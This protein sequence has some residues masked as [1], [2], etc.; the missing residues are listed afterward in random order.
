MFGSHTPFRQAMRMKIQRTCLLTLCIFFL[1]F[2]AA[3]AAE[4]S[5]IVEPEGHQAVIQA[6]K[7]EV[8][9]LFKSAVRW[10]RVGLL[11]RLTLTEGIAKGDGLVLNLFPDTSYHATI[12]R[13]SVNVQGTITVRGRLR[14]YPLGYVLISTTGDLS[15]A[16]IRVPELGAEYTIVYDPDSKAHYLLDNDPSKLD[17]LEDAPAVIPPL[18][19]RKNKLKSRHFENASCSIKSPK[20]RLPRSMSWWFTHRQHEHGPIRTKAVSAML[21]PRP[22]KKLSSLRITAA[23]LLPHT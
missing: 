3:L 2:S 12:D 7:A 5:L 13:V 20:M 11:K 15:L 22:W 8:K 16:T 4:F 23:R 9:G 18:P 6:Q 17:E 10:R 1:N 19:N 14:N 21:L